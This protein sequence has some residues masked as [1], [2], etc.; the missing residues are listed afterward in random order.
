MGGGG[1][2][3]Q[4]LRRRGALVAGSSKIGFYGLVSLILR[5][6]EARHVAPH[7]RLASC[8]FAAR[9]SDFFAELHDKSVHVMYSCSEVR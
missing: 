8:R 9:G 6:V 2:R 4:N 1:G 7:T 3:G 5:R